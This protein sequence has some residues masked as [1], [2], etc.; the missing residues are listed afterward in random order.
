MITDEGIRQLS[1]GLCM[2]DRLRVLELDNCPLITDMSLE[3]LRECRT[4]ERVEL[5][6]CQQI[7][8]SGICKFKVSDK[9]TIDL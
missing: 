7:T 6:D 3:H 9:T 1:L 4:L 2:N 5:Y 8:R